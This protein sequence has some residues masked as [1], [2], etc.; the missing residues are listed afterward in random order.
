[1]TCSLCKWASSQEKRKRKEFKNVCSALKFTLRKKK[2]WKAEKIQ[3]C[4]GSGSPSTWPE[5]IHSG[6]K[7]SSIIDQPSFSAKSKFLLKRQCSEIQNITQLYFL[8][9]MI[10]MKYPYFKNTYILQN[11]W[12]PHVLRA[13]SS[14]LSTLLIIKLSINSSLVRQGLKGSWK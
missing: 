14:R 4:N 3:E 11:V 13:F 1:M 5:K 12:L 10:W 8:K 2:G 6:K 7:H 9:M